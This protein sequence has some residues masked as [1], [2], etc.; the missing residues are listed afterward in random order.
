MIASLLARLDD[1]RDQRPA[2]VALRGAVLVAG[3]AGLYLIAAV[4]S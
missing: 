1:D 2:L 4:L 3:L